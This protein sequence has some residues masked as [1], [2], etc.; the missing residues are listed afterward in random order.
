MTGATNAVHPGVRRLLAEGV[1]AAK[2]PCMSNMNLPPHTYLKRIPGVDA[3]ACR[4]CYT[5]STVWDACDTKLMTLCSPDPQAFRPPEEPVN[6]LQVRLATNFKSAP[7]DSD[8]HYGD[9]AATRRRRRRRAVRYR[10]GQDRIAGQAERSAR[11]PFSCTARES[12][13]C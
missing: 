7:F 11:F 4:S 3:A 5:D 10:I 12:G 6:V 9:I 8:A 13:A 1:A 2:V